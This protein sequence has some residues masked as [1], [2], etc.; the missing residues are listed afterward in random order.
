MAK[1]FRADRL[2]TGVLIGSASGGKPGVLIYSGNF[3]QNYDG[4]VTDSNMLSAVG[5]D[6]G[7]FVSGSKGQIT[8]AGWE[9]YG[10]GKTGYSYQPGVV[11]FGGDLHVSGTIRAEHIVGELDPTATGS[12]YLSGALFVGKG[13]TIN[14][15]AGIDEHHDFKVLGDLVDGGE[16]I[17]F[18]DSGTGKVSIGGS[19]ATGTGR[20]PG[21]PIG[22]LEV[23]SGS[24]GDSNIVIHSSNAKSA[25]L[26]FYQG[27]VPGA[28]IVQSGSD[29]SEDLYIDNLAANESII[30]RT[31]SNA[32]SYGKDV[33]EQMRIGGA[34]T[35]GDVSVGIGGATNLSAS[36]LQINTFDGWDRG[37]LSIFHEETGAGNWAINIDAANSG[38][39][40]NASGSGLESYSKN[41]IYAEQDESSGYGL[42]VYRDV[43]ESGLYA[44]ATFHDDNTSNTQPT[45]AIR[46]DGTGY[47]LKLNDGGTDV[48]VVEDGGNVGLGT[49]AGSAGANLDVRTHSSTT[50]Q[51]GSHDARSGSLSFRK[52]VGE[53]G[54]A[55]VYDNDENIVLVSS[56]SNKEFLFKNH[57]DT[58][59]AR[60]REPVDDKAQVL[61]LSGARNNSA[62]TNN[63]AN[64]ADANFVVSGS[65]N[66]RTGST[67]GTAVFMGDVHV[68]GNISSDLTNFGQ[69]A[70]RTAG[71]THLYALNPST[72]SVSIGKATAAG[73]ASTSDIWLA[74]DGAAVF[75]QQGN[76]VD[77]RVEGDT[78]THLLYV[79]GTEDRVSIG[80]N[81]PTGFFEVDLS[82][83]GVDRRPVFFG[84]SYGS[85]G[86][87][88]PEGGTLHLRWLNSTD[89]SRDAS[90]FIESAQEQVGNHSSSIVFKDYSVGVGSSA[91]FVHSR[92]GAGSGTPKFTM[93]NSGTG[94][95]LT[96]K[97][98][99]NTTHPT[100]ML[101]MQGANSGIA[102]VVFNEDQADLDFTVKTSGRP[103]ALVIDS[104]KDKVLI[105]SGGA[106]ASPNE[107]NFEDISLFVSGAKN[108]RYSD[109]L[110]LSLFG[111]DVA[112]SGA[113]YGD[114]RL[115]IGTPTGLATATRKYHPG[116]AEIYASAPEL[117]LTSQGNS[118]SGSLY[119][120]EQTNLGSKVSFKISAGGGLGSGAGSNNQNGAILCLTG[121]YGAERDIVFQTTP[122]GGAAN[123]AKEMIRIGGYTQAIGFFGVSDLTGSKIDIICDEDTTGLAQKHG[124]TLVQN[125]TGGN[126]SALVIDSAGGGAA[127]S[128]TGKKPAY[129][130]QDISSG[131]GL[132][133]YRDISEA[134]SNPLVTFQDDNTTNTQA[135]LRVRQDGTGNIAEFQDAASTAVVIADGGNVGI[136]N[137]DP[138][139]NLV[140]GDGTG[141][142]S[143]HV[144]AGGGSSGSLGFSKDGGA[145][146]ARITLNSSENL[147]L[148]TTGSSGNN[149][150]II[151]QVNDGGTDTRVMTIDGSASSVAIGVNTN[152]V[153]KLKVHVADGDSVDGIDIVNVD[154]GQKAL[155]IDSEGA[156]VEINA[157]E[158]L[159]ITNDIAGGY[160]AIIRR[161]LDAGDTS[162]PLVFI[163]DQDG[164]QIALK[165]TQESTNTSAFAITAGNAG[166]VKTTI[167]GSGQVGIG[168]GTNSFAAMVHVKGITRGQGIILEDASSTDTVV[169]IYE[170]LDDGVID[171]YQ[172]NSVDSRIHGNGTSFIGSSNTAAF[173]LGTSTPVSE[174]EIYSIGT[175]QTTAMISAVSN[176]SGSLAFRKNF[177]PTAAAI[178]LD[179]DDHFNLINSGSNKDIV[180]ETTGTGQIIASGSL[181]APSGLSGSLTTLTDGTPYLRPGN[182]ITI[183]SGSADYITITAADG[184]DTGASYLV[185]SAT[186]SLDAERVFTVDAGLEANDA[187]AGGAYTIKI[188]YAGA[189][190]FILAATDGT[191]ITVDSSNDKLALYDNDAGVVK[192]VNANQVGNTYTAG[193]G[194]DLSGLEFGV[195]LKSS[196]GLKIDTTELAVEPADFAG[197]GLEDDGSDNLRIKNSVVATLTGSIFSGKVGIHTGSHNTWVPDAQLE[198]RSATSELDAGI[199]ITAPT[200]ASGSLIFRQAVGGA[201]K[202]AL[203]Y[204]PDESLVLVNS[205]SNDDVILKYNNSGTLK[206]FKIDASANDLILDTGLA[207]YFKDTDG[208]SITSSNAA[209]TRIAIDAPATDSAAM[210][211]SAAGL[212]N[213]KGQNPSS[214]TAGNVKIEAGDNIKFRTTDNTGTFRDG[215]IVIQGG[216]ATMEVVV[217]EGSR[218]DID[219]RVE[220]DSSQKAIYV[221]A[222]GGLAGGGE[223]HI[224]GSGVAGWSGDFNVHSSNRNRTLFVDGQSHKVGILLNDDTTD[225]P[226]AEL[227]IGNGV[228]AGPISTLLNVDS[229]YSGSFALSQDDTGTVGA[230]VLDP[231]GGGVAPLTLVH[232]GANSSLNLKTT[233]ATSYI[234]LGRDGSSTSLGTDV[235]IFFSGSTDSK[236]GNGRGTSL[237]GGDAAISGSLYIADRIYHGGD[238][239]T[240]LGFTNNSVRIQAGGNGILSHTAGETPENITINADGANLATIIKTQNKMAIITKAST[241]QVL[242]LS[243]GGATSFNEGNTDDVNFYVSGSVGSRSSSTRG[244]AVFGGDLHV[245]GTLT[246]DNTS[247]G[248]WADGGTFLYPSDN[249][250]AE[251]VIIG[252]SGVDSAHTVLGSDGQ[253]Q[254]NQQNEAVD[255]RVRSAGN[256]HMLNLSGGINAITIG[257]QQTAGQ[258]VILTVSGAILS[259]GV[260]ADRGIS[261]FGG[262]TYVSG[263]LLLGKLSST[264]S[265]ANI[266]SNTV[267]LYGKDDGG[268]TK[269][270]YMDD[271]GTEIMVGSGGG[272][273]GAADANASFL[274]L[275]A[276]GSLNAERV[277]T[278]GSG[279]STTDGGAGN[280]YTVAIDYA[281]ADSFILAATDGTGITVD[282][283][284]DKLVLYDND[285]AAV[286][287]VNANQV[288]TTYTAGDGLDLSGTEFSTDIKTGGGLVIDSTELAI[289]NSV[290]ATISGSQFSGNVGVTGSFG[291][292]GGALFKSNVTLG[293]ATS[294]D[295]T[296]TGRVASH[297]LPSADSTYNLGS[298]A[299]RFANIYTGDLHLRNEKGNWT[300]QEEADRLIVINNL[301]GKKYKMMLSPL[302]DEE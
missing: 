59:F 114:G 154:A 146:A 123:A 253:V 92:E 34:S 3:A 9:P 103:A 185:L 11:L 88:K 252:A 204:D 94:G 298:D 285:A 191:G 121:S 152:T 214:T 101:R 142:R 43:A 107:S 246:S 176:S 179:S 153:S 150:D 54:A 213:I 200:D 45:V 201:T 144:D 44:L 160:G 173:G 281:G 229:S 67:R 294:D 194:L 302:E 143:I 286:K 85:S 51:I 105:L 202:A 226:Q 207:V 79:D 259:R 212:L 42:K 148:A 296:F 288:G 63:P 171:V 78:L 175:D 290:A 261:A 287:Y 245:S 289:D 48:F 258:D 97:A 14:T 96:F 254:F 215:H 273:G 155:D 60:F 280:A 7:I 187:G 218:A 300:I 164:D 22:I 230:L 69:W 168:K 19:S 260:T 4:G 89:A 21:V 141:V 38:I 1:D 83:Q 208:A 151:F 98:G 100:T 65:I 140:V 68:S 198:I 265:Q 166:G 248:Q 113:L 86:S 120:R 203:V 225:R 33:W 167:S 293:N 55:L 137:T 52:H 8:P 145:T 74:S 16:T 116:T 12:L 127:L 17:I 10:R 13:A 209:G 70:R 220:T 37:A 269:L 189:D 268:T 184:G 58:I 219:F 235:N 73:A 193:D 50:I 223:V 23:G 84:Q 159:D 71:K 76:V 109:Q 278:A 41:A 118:S 110:G 183:E 237:F 267:G 270:F 301:T 188:D 299:L 25:S 271:A 102:G 256:S 272:G 277:F 24:I 27:G 181:M 91:G 125:E 36:V 284:N 263:A 18:A 178:V 62:E 147:V 232:S 61:I 243:G 283:A 15:W 295:L 217:N 169:K 119:F 264:P 111:G 126:K 163:R 221:D 29:G 28:R 238:K 206:E 40:V 291:V 234:T 239:D 56:A 133:V 104:G 297:I 72:D 170:S 161:N 216:A 282:G 156:G 90:M 224:G 117:N 66:S 106:V 276:T 26:D 249:S 211:L 130:K 20:Q 199:M 165:V 99:S 257:Q 279:I 136:G 95:A 129:L 108:T 251:T 274:V 196:G 139:A 240:Y 75:N 31:T 93:V 250:G 227:Q 39:K 134:G 174:F 190:S 80:N 231:S 172:N 195:D 222:D 53:V 244:T 128:V 47:I 186:S 82:A 210:A 64:Y 112:V 131:Y 157:K 32:G 275:T 77:F 6:V 30:L 205:S 135:T 132:T 115:Q 46:Q 292:T 158:A 197:T 247:F 124:M 122:D 192:Y 255:L 266:G 87:Y 35:A 5:C 262:D 149:K 180:L 162:N 236:D 242:I 49:A 138:H 182:N 81:D 57:N 228:H 241:D 2:R 177:M 233:Q